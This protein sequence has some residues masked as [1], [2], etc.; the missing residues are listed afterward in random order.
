MV[1][2]RAESADVDE[3]FPVQDRGTPTLGVCAAEAAQPPSLQLYAR[4]PRAP[5][6]REL[7][8]VRPHSPASLREGGS[9]QSDER[10]AAVQ[11][12][13][14][15]AMRRRFS[16]MHTSFHSARTRC[17]P[18]MLNCRNPSTFLI[19]PLGGSAI[20]FRLR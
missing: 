15:T 19:Q 8:R 10:F 1:R 17:S 14:N 16:A 5:S 20:H 9:S 11:L 4:L 6:V 3:P 2:F 7:Q 13:P 12:A 18:R